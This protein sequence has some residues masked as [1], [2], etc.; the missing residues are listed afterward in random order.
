[1]LI[2]SKVKQILTCGSSVFGWSG[3]WIFKANYST[4]VLPLKVLYVYVA[5]HSEH[6]IEADGKFQRVSSHIFCLEWQFWPFL[7]R[8]VSSVDLTPFNGL[9]SLGGPYRAT[10]PFEVAVVVEVVVVS[11]CVGW[12]VAI[13]HDAVLLYLHFF[14][15]HLT[16]G[17]LMWAFN[18]PPPR[19][20]FC[21]S[22][23]IV[24]KAL[25]RSASVQRNNT[26][27]YWCC[28]I[29]TPTYAWVKTTNLRQ[30]KEHAL[31]NGGSWGSK[32]QQ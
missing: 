8:C 14:M 6:N 22:H 1:M 19:V 16:F 15:C 28:A 2:S 11:V 20:S 12:G 30:C 4:N 27:R 7:K 5:E 26:P 18:S 9:A 21:S 32:L 29:L 31:K 3:V 10:Q 24:N 13:C 23:I 25:T 17:S